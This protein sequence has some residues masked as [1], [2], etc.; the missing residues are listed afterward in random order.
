[1]TQRELQSLVKNGTTYGY[2]RPTPTPSITAMGPPSKQRKMIDGWFTGEGS[3]KLP[4][5]TK[6][7]A[8]TASVSSTDEEFSVKPEDAGEV[9]KEENP[10]SSTTLKPAA[11]KVAKSAASENVKQEVKREDSVVPGGSTQKVKTLQVV[12]IQ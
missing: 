8:R 11:Q 9:K 2:K 1:M 7:G 10:E 12:E 4:S 3:E 6:K 5:F